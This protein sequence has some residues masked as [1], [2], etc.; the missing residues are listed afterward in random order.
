[1]PYLENRQRVVIVDAV[2][3]KSTPGKILEAGGDQIPR[4]IGTKLS[5]HQVNLHEILSLLDL[6]DAKPD[7]LRLIGIQPRHQHF[8]QPLSEEA[9]RAIPAVMDR[10]IARVRKWK[11]EAVNASDECAICAG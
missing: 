9:Q 3:F 10:I 4:F 2:D 6:L 11:E 7:D 5:E 8:A 1:L